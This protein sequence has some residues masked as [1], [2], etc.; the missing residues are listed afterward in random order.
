MPKFTTRRWVAFSP[1]QMYDVVADVE[2]YPDFLPLC[3]GLRVLSR[4]KLENKEELTAVM[5]VGYKAIRESFT[6]RVELDPKTPRIDVSY[7][8]GP[9][10]YLNN[11]WQFEKNGTGCDVSFFIDYEFKSAVIGML[12]GAMFDKAFRKFSTAFEE[13]AKDVYSA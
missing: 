5:D 9:F 7:L 11:N 6:T 12:V 3:E 2:S 13:R 1:R 8:D 10:R 4:T